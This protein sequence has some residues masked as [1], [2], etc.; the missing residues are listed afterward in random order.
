MNQKKEIASLLELS[1]VG[2]F[3]VKNSVVIL[4]NSGAK[5][6][7]IEIG[8]CAADL[9]ATGGEEY[10]AFTGGCLSLRLGISGVYFDATVLRMEGFDLFR[11]ESEDMRGELQTLA[12][13]ARSLREPLNALFNS[14]D[15]LFPELRAKADEKAQGEMANINRALYRLLRLVG[16]MSDPLRYLRSYGGFEVRDACALI[17]EA[18]EKAAALLSSAGIELKYRGAESGVYTLVHAELLERAVF[19]LLSNA[20]KFTR[21]GGVIQACLTRGSGTL[22]LRVE[23]G[24][25]QR[26][27]GAL[28][29]IFSKFLREPSAED[30]R[31]GLGLGLTIVRIAASRHNG[32]VL[33]EQTPSGQLRVSMTIAARRVTDLPLHSPIFRMDY[34][35]EYDHARVELSDVLPTLVYRSE[36]IN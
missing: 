15:A 24:E 27:D 18:M 10:A 12:L 23:G 34:A 11:L 36:E 25:C 16:N 14:T 19:N 13:A 7:G 30:P 35:G 1:Q 21:K 29:G 17:D 26:G 2:A 31:Q 9:I 20:A 33:L 4:A 28:S 5:N 6:I 8:L 22:L 3:C 32:T